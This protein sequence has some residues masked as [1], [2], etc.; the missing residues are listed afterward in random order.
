MGRQSVHVFARHGEGESCRLTTRGLIDTEGRIEARQQQR[1]HNKGR[2][3]KGRGEEILH[4]LVLGLSIAF[5]HKVPTW[6]MGICPSRF[7]ITRRSEGIKCRLVDQA[8][9]NVKS[10]IPGH[11][12]RSR[13]PTGLQGRSRTP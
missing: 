12:T 13:C 11:G 7:S 5:P 8:R 10:Q 2:G 6:G 3:S 9:I 4:Y 1:R